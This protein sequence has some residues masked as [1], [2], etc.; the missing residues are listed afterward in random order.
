MVLFHIV[1]ISKFHM[2][3]S[4]GFC[5]FKTSCCPILIGIVV[6]ACDLIVRVFEGRPSKLQHITLRALVRY[7]DPL[8]D[9]MGNI[10]PKTLGFKKSISQLI[11]PAVGTNSCLCRSI[12]VIETSKLLDLYIVSPFV[13]PIC[14]LDYVTFSVHPHK[15]TF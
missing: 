9:K 14:S 8:V 6:D 4:L 5:L 7:V 1:F 13:M 10:L 2:T 15:K 11:Y 3:T 12:G